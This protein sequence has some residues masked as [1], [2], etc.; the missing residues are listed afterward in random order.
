MRILSALLLAAAATFG[1]ASIKDCDPTSV[2]RPT[3]LAVS[4]DP[5]VRGQPVTLTV[6]FENPGPVIDAGSVTTSVTLNGLPFSPSTEAL[7]ENTACPIP[8]D[9]VDRSTTSTWPTSVGGKVVTKS[10]WFSENGA[11]LLCVQT[12]LTVA[13]GKSLRQPLNLTAEF[14]ETIAHLWEDDASAKTVAPWFPITSM[15]V[16]KYSNESISNTDLLF[17]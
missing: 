16:K 8:T 9:D 10:Q 17:L 15:L 7:C 13:T 4:P 1:A 11:S 2:F 14:N 12:S 3:E 6:R 5:P